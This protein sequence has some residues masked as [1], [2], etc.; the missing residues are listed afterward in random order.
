MDASHCYGATTLKYDDVTIER[1]VENAGPGV[2]HRGFFRETEISIWA[3]HQ[4]SGAS[5]RACASS[6]RDEDHSVDHSG[7]ASPINNTV[8]A[9]HGPNDIETMEHEAYVISKLRHP[10]VMMFMGWCPEIPCIITEWC[11]KGSLACVLKQAAETGTQTLSWACRLRIAL[12]IAKGMLYLHTH[13]PPIVHG[14]LSS[15]SIMID[16]NWTA[17]V[18]GFGLCHMDATPQP[19]RASHPP[20]SAAFLAPEVLLGRSTSK[21]SDVYA[22][23]VVMWELLTWQEPWRGMP[24]HQIKTSV[25]HRSERPH[26]DLSAED[27]LGGTFDHINDYMSLICACWADASGSRPSFEQIIPKLRHMVQYID[28][29]FESETSQHEGKPRPT[30]TF[31]KRAS[32]FDVSHAPAIDRASG[33]SLCSGLVQTFRKLQGLQDHH[34][35]HHHGVGGFDDGGG[36]TSARGPMLFDSCAWAIGAKMPDLTSS[37]PLNTY[38]KGE[39][40]IGTLPV[41]V[42][43]WPDSSTGDYTSHVASCTCASLVAHGKRGNPQATLKGFP[44]GEF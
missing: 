7:K 37:V 29:E 21:A 25:L 17:K 28:A 35:N 38:L 40:P 13:E 27:L 33:E 6:T 24:A 20:E 11:S 26:F 43:H 32:Q 3:L 9:A 2:L 1:Q 15:K 41:C 8:H 14:N 22:F 39:G 42:R 12:G 44:I 31:T 34:H 5:Q 30:I 36:N 19:P 18:T 4:L 23:A 10:H 16:V